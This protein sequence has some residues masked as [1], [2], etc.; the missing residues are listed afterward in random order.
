MTERFAFL[1]LQTQAMTYGDGALSPWP[2]FPR[3]VGGPSGRVELSGVGR[4]LLDL[5]E[6]KAPGA[7][8]CFSEFQL[9]LVWVLLSVISTPL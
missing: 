4:A 6:G 1:P 8:I 3:C 5:V 9:L 7:D 2:P